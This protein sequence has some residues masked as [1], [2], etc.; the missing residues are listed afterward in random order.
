MNNLQRLLDALEKTVARIEQFL[1]ALQSI[2]NQAKAALGVAFVVLQY[3]VDIAIRALRAAAE[4]VLEKIREYLEQG[5]EIVQIFT[6]QG[7]WRDEVA[8]PFAQISADLTGLETKKGAWSGEAYDS[9]SSLT[10]SQGEAASK[11]STAASS[12]ANSLVATGVGLIIFYAGV[13]GATVTVI[14]GL[15][16]AGAAT[17]TGVGAP[18]GAAAAGLT[19]LQW[20]A[21]V[22]SLIAASATLAGVQVSQ[23]NSIKSVTLFGG[24]SPFAGN[25][26]PD[27]NR[28]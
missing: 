27:G 10:A 25:K 9:Y 23:I 6:A 1:A 14:V 12:I 3:L 20:A 19:A 24:S 17:A 26:W 21:V 28:E 5:F 22:V 7:V 11:L 16:A 2:W 4:I 13:V 18:A 15:T 8:A